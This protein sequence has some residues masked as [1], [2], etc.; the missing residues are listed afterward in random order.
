MRHAPWLATRTAWLLAAVATTVAC[1]RPA[2]PKPAPTT[3]PQPKP[4]PAPAPGADA[5]TAQALQALEDEGRDAARPLLEGALQAWESESGGPVEFFDVSEGTLSPLVLGN[6]ELAL[7]PSGAWLAR[8]EGNR[9]SVF[10][11][12]D[13]RR[14]RIFEGHRGLVLSLA[15]APDGNRFWSS[16]EDGTVRLWDIPGARL[17]HTSTGN[18][19]VGPLLLSPD[20]SRIVYRCG[21]SLCSWKAADDR[22]E[23][24]RLRVPEGCLSLRH[25]HQGD[26]VITGEDGEEACYLNVA[27]GVV[28]KTLPFIAGALVFPRRGDLFLAALPTARTVRIE[29]WSASRGQR[30]RSL[31]TTDENGQRAVALAVPSLSP[32]GRNAVALT[33][34]REITRWDTTTGKVDARLTLP[35]DAGRADYLDDG[36]VLL[37]WAGGGGFGLADRETTAVQPARDIPRMVYHTLE[38]M[39]DGEGF[40]AG[41]GDRIQGWDLDSGTPSFE[42]HDPD[43]IGRTW[44]LRSSP[45]GK[46][47]AA[48]HA[49]GVR[50]WDLATRQVVHREAPAEGERI[51][52][53]AFDAEGRLVTTRSVHPPRGNRRKDG[54][55]CVTALDGTDTPESCW[56]VGP[57]AAVQISA[58]A[59]RVAVAPPGR[60]IRVFEPGRKA[61]LR[62]L[63]VAGTWSLSPDGDWIAYVGTVAK[64]KTDATSLQVVRV[65]DGTE[66]VVDQAPTPAGPLAWRPDG[67]LFAAAVVRGDGMHD[68]VLVDPASRATTF[69]AMLGKPPG[70]YYLTLMPDGAHLL[71][72]YREGGMSFH[73]LQD[74]EAVASVGFMDDGQTWLVWTDA[75][76][77]DMGGPRANRLIGCRAGFRVLPFPL[78]EVRFRKPGLLGDALGSASDP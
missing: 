35:E 67:A 47:L 25:W 15:F 63:P 10:T 36:R 28:E 30:V 40:V 38:L 51:T 14:T 75:G 7:A 52:A 48:L 34:P 72:R 73:R 43:P 57:H 76:L 39:T 65:S 17:V 55:V 58:E 78:C 23:R 1:A 5:L 11:A 56:F 53:L 69:R 50:V 18:E 24:R 41:V 44:L 61:L 13:W 54:R 37:S 12:D 66:W 9:V 45:D 29:V 31:A 33:H 60:G 71:V 20:G 26:T 70:A 42:L 3:A 27:T 77:F 2:P 19:L 46:R 4:V 62:E 49:R 68:V 59:E 22:P 21:H 8:S 64:A 32:D 74:G 16:G 6:A